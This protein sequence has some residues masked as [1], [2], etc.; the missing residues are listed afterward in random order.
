MLL[1]VRFLLLLLFRQI[2]E[3]LRIF[4]GHIGMS[5]PGSE[6]PLQRKG[7]PSLAR[8][9]DGFSDLGRLGLVL[10]PLIQGRNVSA[11]TQDYELKLSIQMKFDT[12]IS[13]LKSY[14]QYKIAH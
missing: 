13:N 7:R 3:K 9:A 14:F 8:R 10:E 12:L 4:L 2:V 5:Y 6:V 11:Y 1:L